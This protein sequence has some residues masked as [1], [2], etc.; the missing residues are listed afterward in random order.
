MCHDICYRDHG[1]K[2]EGKY[3]CHDIMLEELDVIEPKNIR[4]KIKR[5]LV[6][7][8]IGVKKKLGLGVIEWS[9]PL[10]SSISL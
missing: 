10:T 2:N 5:R 9:D 7:S 8:L 1:D 4:E 3:D 6:K